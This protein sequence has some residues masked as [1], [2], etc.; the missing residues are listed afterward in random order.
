MVRATHVG[1]FDFVQ[2]ND[3]VVASSAGKRSVLY[4]AVSA[5]GKATL[6]L[7]RAFH[8]AG[9]SGPLLKFSD[10]AQK[11]GIGR[12]ASMDA[13]IRKLTPPTAQDSIYAVISSKDGGA[14][15]SPVGPNHKVAESIVHFP[16]DPGDTQGGYNLTIAVS[17]V[18]LNT[19]AFGVKA[20]P[21]IGRNTPGAFT[22]EEHGDE[23]SL[24]GASPHIHGD[25]HGLRFD[26][27]DR[28]GRT[29]FMCSDGGL[30]YT[31]DLSPPPTPT[32]FNSSVNRSLPVLQFMSYPVR[33]TFNGASGVS[34]ATPGLVAGPLQDNGVVF[35]FFQNRIQRPWQRIT[36]DDGE[37]GIF[38][39]NDL[40][41]FW[42]GGPVARVAKWNGSQFGEPTN[43]TVRKSSP[44]FPTGSTFSGGSSVDSAPA[45]WAETI[46]H[47]QFKRPD[48]QQTM[49]AVA[50]NPS[51]APSELW[52]L[53]TNSDGSDPHWDFLTSVGLDSGDRITAVASDDGLKAL[54]GSQRGKIFSYDVASR[55]VSPMQFDL[56]LSFLARIL[57]SSSLKEIASKLDV[58]PPV[59]LRNV[60]K[61]AVQ[62]QVFQFAFLSNGLA[63]ARYRSSL[64]RFE[65]AKNA[66]TSIQGNGLPSNEGSLY[67]MAVDTGRGPAILY[68]ATDY[69]VHASWDAGEN[70]LPVSQGL[71]VRSQPST[72]RFVTEPAGDRQL[73][74]FTWGRSAWRARLN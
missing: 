41:L 71:P 47:P 73:Y 61:L 63:I 10:L 15:W 9:S 55:K 40:L 39:K 27:Q 58:H 49:V 34:F 12:P 25:C 8:V 53:F 7:K 14:T 35:S 60:L 68:V 19:I 13:V 56:S 32:T 67:F 21:W 46:F 48:T 22:W 23:A 20:G 70:W 57:K 28:T 65:P 16:R 59:S 31:T 1:D 43:V 54:V 26:S 50:A 4:A 45:L 37:M 24:T 52:G 38:L 42:D 33:A 2:W 5:S 51:K 44:T 62:Q 6:S 64:L 72:L 30:V 18:D 36:E 69:G 3:A 17:N 29:L 74:L 11:V 66:W